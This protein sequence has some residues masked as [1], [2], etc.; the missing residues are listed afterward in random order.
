[1]TNALFCQFVN[2][3]RKAKRSQAV[4]NEVRDI[5]IDEK[6]FNY[7]ETSCSVFNFSSRRMRLEIVRR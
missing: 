1:M 4:W 7:R 5:I 3:E 2:D 6:F